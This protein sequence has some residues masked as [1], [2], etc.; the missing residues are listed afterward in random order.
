VTT[1]T[2]TA[3]DVRDFLVRHLAEIFS[4]MLALPALP[5][6]E[7]VSGSTLE[8]V[9]GSVGFVG[10]AVAGAVY[11]HVP[12][13][14][15]GRI[16]CA[17]LGTPPEE[18]PGDADVNDVMGEVTNMLAGGLKSWLCDAGAPCAL[19]T[20]AIIRGSSFRILASE[21]VQQIQFPFASDA[22]RGLLEVHF[23]FSD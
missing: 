13:A 22:Y 10:A 16:T 20:P 3:S 12:A 19:A 7:A 4:T 2:I 17:M 6:T 23:K 9:S 8:R 14:F 21:G 15:A 5:V 1:Q 18:V 11:L